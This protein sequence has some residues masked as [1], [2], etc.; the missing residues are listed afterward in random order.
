MIEQHSIASLS[1][2]LG[3]SRAATLAAISAG[4]L[5][6]VEKFTFGARVAYRIEGEAIEAYR[7]QILKKLEAKIAKIS[8]D[9][10][11]RRELMA[12]ALRAIRIEVAAEEAEILT[13]ATL[14]DRLK[15]S[16]EKAAWLLERHAERAPG[17]FRVTP[18][19][20][21][22]IRENLEKLRS[23]APQRNSNT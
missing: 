7:A 14:A 23:T 2:R 12:G 22:K 21:K 11:K 17:G 13:P 4:R 20:M 6:V 15:I 9:L 8:T 3:L 5:P 1:A 18:A 16:L 19:A 10:S